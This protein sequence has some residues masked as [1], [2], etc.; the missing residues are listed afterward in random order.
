MSNESERDTV[1]GSPPAPSPPANPP[2]TQ[3]PMK[4]GPPNPGVVVFFGEGGQR[5]ARFPTLEVA[6]EQAARQRSGQ[7]PLAFY[8]GRHYGTTLAEGAR[9]GLEVAKGQSIEDAQKARPAR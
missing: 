5:R 7:E 1:V 9:P 2:A 8:D 3:K 4:G 6:L